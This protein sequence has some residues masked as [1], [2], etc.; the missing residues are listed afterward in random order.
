[1]TLM[2]PIFLTHSTQALHNYYGQR[3]LALLRESAPV[4]LNTQAQALDMAALIEAARDCPIIVSSRDTPAPAELFA[5]LPALAVFCRVAVDIRNIDVAAASAHGVLITHATPGFDTSVSEWVLGVMLDLARGISRAAAHYWQGQVPAVVMGRELRGATLGIVGYGFIGQRL[6]ALAQALGMQV[7]VCDPQVRVQQASIRQLDF[8]GL[9]G[10]ADYV[11]CLAP[12]TPHTANLFDAKA[13]AAMRRHSFFINASRGELVD[14]DALLEALEC[15]LL[16][17][18]ALDVGRAPDQM[19]SPRL[20]A[21]PAVIA[22]P[23]IGGLTPPASEH[24]AMDSVRQVQ[25]LIRGQWPAG[26]VNAASAH[27]A[28]ETFNLSEEPVH[29]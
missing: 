10:A 1:M 7:L 18:C 2:K 25:A 9:L 8:S 24:Q 3:A 21:H 13:F 27:R 22:S 16:A 28:R 19:P 29:D 20:A 6:A 5:Q 12:A 14:E 26:A 15:G 4:V 11:V 17:G 23:H